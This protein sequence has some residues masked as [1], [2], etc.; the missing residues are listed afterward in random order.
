MS[1]R[2]TELANEYPLHVVTGWLGNT[3]KV[4]SKRTCQSSDARNHSVPAQCGYY[5]PE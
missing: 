3:E 5:P 2:E 1:F 4:A